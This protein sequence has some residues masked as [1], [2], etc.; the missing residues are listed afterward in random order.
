MKKTI[1]TQNICVKDEIGTE[2]MSFTDYLK[3][4]LMFLVAGFITIGW[5]VQ[6][7]QGLVNHDANDYVFP[8]NVFLFLFLS[9]LFIV[10][11]LCASAVII[12]FVYGCLPLKIKNRL[13]PV[14]EKIESL[15]SK[16]N[17]E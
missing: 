16:G 14:L 15:F 6:A 11:I 12:I 2:K 9:L 13:D 1:E 4:L 17:P 5:V 3:A 10:G 8:V 7:Y